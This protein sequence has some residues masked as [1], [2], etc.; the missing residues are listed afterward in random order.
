MRVDPS[1]AEIGI[2]TWGTKIPREYVPV[3]NY[4][5]N[6]AG[7][8]DPQ[9]NRGFKKK[10]LDGRGG[11]IQ[12]YVSED[13]RFVAV[14]DTVLMLAYVHLRSE[15]KDNKWLSIGLTDYHGLWIA[16]AVGELVADLLSDLNYKVSLFHYDITRL[17]QEVKK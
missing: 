6:V 2:Y 8:R 17:I 10:F 13:P 1:Q 12:E 16:P 15:A 7:F 11:E 5:V 3:A 9:S 14:S 4:I